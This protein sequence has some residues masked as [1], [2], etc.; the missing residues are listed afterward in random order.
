MLY[1]LR[2]FGQFLFIKMV[3]G[4]QCLREMESVSAG[5]CLTTKKS[6]RLILLG[7]LIQ[8]IGKSNDLFL[9]C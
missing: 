9:C 1:P 8:A 2:Q 3:N 5:N 6:F 7:I 4:V